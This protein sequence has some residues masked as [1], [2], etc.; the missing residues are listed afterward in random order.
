MIIATNETLQEFITNHLDAE[1]F[2]YLV[3]ATDDRL[4]DE[5]LCIIRRKLNAFLKGD[6]YE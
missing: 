3:L 5:A 4:N 6:N 1:D 2:G